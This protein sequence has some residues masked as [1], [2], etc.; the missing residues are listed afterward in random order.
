MPTRFLAIRRRKRKIQA[1]ALGSILGAR[2]SWTLLSMIERPSSQALYVWLSRGRFL[3]DLVRVI[4]PLISEGVSSK[5]QI[6]IAPCNN[7]AGPSV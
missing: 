6:S 3:G 7:H 4:K 1:T 5:V 2:P